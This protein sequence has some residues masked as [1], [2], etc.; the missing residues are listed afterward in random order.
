MNTTPATQDWTVVTLAVPEEHAD[1]TAQ[2]IRDNLDTEPIQLCRPN[3][4]HTWIEVYY[5]EALHALLAQKALLSAF[6]HFTTTLRGCQARDWQAF[7]K[8]H[9]HP[10]DIGQK[11]RIIPSWEQATDPQRLSIVLDPG[12]SFGTGDHFTTRFCLEQ[13]DALFST[14]PPPQSMLDA[15]TG[16]GILSIAAEKLGCP[17]IDAFDFDPLCLEYTRQNLALNHCTRINLF[18]HD[19]THGLTDGPYDLVCANI[20]SRLLIECAADLVKACTRYLIVTGIQQHESDNVSHAF[21]A[22]G[23][24]EVTWDGSGEWC[25]MVFRQES[26]GLLGL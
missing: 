24:S 26:V 22:H 23:L 13:I 8:N 11:L 12:L 18:E 2:W 20:Y 15:G 10:T 5:A 16:S 21:L 7:W 6:P 19:I 17:R 9:F 4:A 1:Q 3:C 25:G 14:D